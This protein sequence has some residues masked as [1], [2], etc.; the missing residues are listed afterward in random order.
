M[1]NIMKK[2]LVTLAVL[3]M[4]LL[5]GMFVF[6]EIQGGANQGGGITGTANNT[7]TP[8]SQTQVSV[9]LDNPIKVNNFSELVSKVISTAVLVIMPF[10]VVY[11]IYAGFL[12]VKAQGKPEDIAEAKTAM[13]YSIIGAFILL[14]AQAFAQIIGSTVTNITGVQ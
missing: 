9:K 12:F 11:F 14:G 3:S 13:T 6:A 10:V 8:A 7:A 4:L 5:P 1:F 2:N